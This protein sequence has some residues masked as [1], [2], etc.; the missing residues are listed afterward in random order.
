VIDSLR[1]SFIASTLRNIT[2]LV[3]WNANEELRKLVSEQK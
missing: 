3:M 1:E 2:S